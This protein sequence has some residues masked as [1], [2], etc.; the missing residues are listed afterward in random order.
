MKEMSGQE[1]IG[2]GSLV[3]T[4]IFPRVGPTSQA[5]A[6]VGRDARAREAFSRE[7]RTE[8]IPIGWESGRQESLVCS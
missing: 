4:F 2:F 7:P 8:R 1:W 6:Q 3:A 5:H